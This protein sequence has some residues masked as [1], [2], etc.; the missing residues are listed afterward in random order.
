MTRKV[1]LDLSLQFLKLPQIKIKVRILLE[2]QFY[3][4]VYRLEL[5]VF[6]QR[7]IEFDNEM[8]LMMIRVLIENA[9]EELYSNFSIDLVNS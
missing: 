8:N 2:Q 4:Y 7:N 5:R 1:A 3:I 9:S 6:V